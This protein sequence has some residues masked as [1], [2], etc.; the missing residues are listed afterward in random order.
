MYNVLY[1]VPILYKVPDG[2]LLVPNLLS[3]VRDLIILLQRF[4][5]R[6]PMG[7]VGPLS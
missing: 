7:M 1:N 2:H 3:L 5:A 4:E 6:H